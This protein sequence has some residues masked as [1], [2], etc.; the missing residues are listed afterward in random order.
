MSPGWRSMEEVLWEPEEFPFT[1]TPGPINAAAELQ[2]DQPVD[3]FSLFVTDELLDHIVHQTNIYAKESIARLPFL[4]H[5][6][7][8]KW[9]DVTREELK[10]FFGLYFL[11]GLLWKPHLE[12]YWS[13]EEITSTPYFSKV[14]S[15]NRFQNI[16]RFLHFSDKVD[17]NDRLHKIRPVFESLIQ[18][19]QDLYQP[20]QKIS[21]DEGTL[22]FRGRLSFRVF[23]PRQFL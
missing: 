14:M 8:N 20:A 2:S 23:S 1:A 9:Q 13:T 16:L 10:S 3:F 6:R 22:L 19:F 12:L 15:R 4:P 17:K 5:S 7:A 18:K 21:I 11:T